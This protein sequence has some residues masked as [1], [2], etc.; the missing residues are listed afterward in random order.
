MKK[1]PV[2]RYEEKNSKNILRKEQQ[3]DMK[4]RIAKRCEEKTSKV[5]VYQRKR[6]TIE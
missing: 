4:K 2:K 3:R 1:R 6:D 5:R